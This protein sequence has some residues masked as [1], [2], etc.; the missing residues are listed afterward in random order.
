MRRAAVGAAGA[1][2][3][4]AAC[5]PGATVPRGAQGPTPAVVWVAGPTPEVRSLV[6]QPAPVGALTAHAARPMALSVG[7]FLAE[8]KTETGARHHLAL[9]L[10][11][12]GENPAVSLDLSRGL[13]V[14]MDGEVYVGGTGTAGG[15]HVQGTAGGRRLSVSIPVALEDL[16]RLIQAHEV[17]IR[18]GGSEALPLSPADR[19]RLRLLVEQL[20]I[21]APGLP[22]TRL[23]AQA[24]EWSPAPS[25]RCARLSS[26]PPTPRP[27]WP[28]GPCASRPPGAAGRRRRFRP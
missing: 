20:P 28:P 13:L 26:P 25:F 18:L 23:L 22:G 15:Y 1:A 11:L 3:L 9:L 27:A 8:L 17:R 7:A 12:D 6:L 24:T 19:D 5:A 4:L 2:I 14:E 10:Q 21:T 16:Q